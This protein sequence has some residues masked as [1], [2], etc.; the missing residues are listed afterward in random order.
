MPLSVSATSAA[1]AAQPANMDHSKQ[2]AA[3]AKLL[4][5]YTTDLQQGQTA[6][7]LQSLAKQITDAAKALGQNVTLPKLNASSTPA[8]TDAGA[9]QVNLRA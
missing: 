8:T 3:L 9:G 6:S 4:R 2:Q 1:A 5:T 7:Q